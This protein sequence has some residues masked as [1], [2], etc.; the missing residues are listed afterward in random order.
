MNIR[1]FTG[2]HLKI[3]EVGRQVNPTSLFDSERVR[4]FAN[5]GLKSHFYGWQINLEADCFVNQGCLNDN[6]F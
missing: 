3:R 2:G 6:L 5:I 1:E 4:L